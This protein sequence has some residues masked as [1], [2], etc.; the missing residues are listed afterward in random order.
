MFICDECEAMWHT[1]CIDKGAFQDF[2]T[3]VRLLGYTYEQVE[4]NDIDYD[5]YQAQDKAD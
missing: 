2:I 4:I 1:S 5:W 3:Y